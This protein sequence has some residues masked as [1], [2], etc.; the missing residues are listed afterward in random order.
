MRCERR[1]SD[2]V[3]QC[4]FFTNFLSILQ[5][6][7]EICEIQLYFSTQ[8]YLIDE[9]FPKI[10]KKFQD[11]FSETSK[12][13]VRRKCRWTLSSGLSGAR[14]APEKIDKNL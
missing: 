6:F 7:S 10:L 11:R 2:K 8:V 5:T 1:G 14:S 9:K 12:N 4:S 13:G 3:I